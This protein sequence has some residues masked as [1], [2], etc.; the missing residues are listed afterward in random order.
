MIY[1]VSFNKI[2]A[3]ASN[4]FL[5]K[6]REVIHKQKH[7]FWLPSMYSLKKFFFECNKIKKNNK[8]KN[9]RITN[10]KY[11]HKNI[12]SFI[13]LYISIINIYLNSSKIL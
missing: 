13:N 6:K 8:I 9:K 5:D 7:F 1:I 10:T 3:F 2:K 4:V 11:H 12:S